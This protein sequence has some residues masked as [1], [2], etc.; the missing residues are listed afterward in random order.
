MCILVTFPAD[1]VDRFFQL[2]P[3]EMGIYAC[4]VSEQFFT[5]IGKNIRVNT[6]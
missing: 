2:V 4:N 6:V 5:I 3:D 1:D